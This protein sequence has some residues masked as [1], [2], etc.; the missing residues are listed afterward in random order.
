VSIVDLSTCAVAS[1]VKAG[2]SPCKRCT[3]RKEANNP[4][5][6]TPPPSDSNPASVEE[7]AA[8][9]Q[10]H[11]K[12]DDEHSGRVHVLSFVFLASAVL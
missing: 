5:E 1:R 7:P 4:G 2:D 12:D 3:F 8:A 6:R 11:E 9:Q 10:Q